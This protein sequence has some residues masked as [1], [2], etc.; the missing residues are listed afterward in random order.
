MQSGISYF[1]SSIKQPYEAVTGDT[2][3]SEEGV[4]GGGAG[5]TG[6]HVTCA[7]RYT[8]LPCPALF[9]YPRRLRKSH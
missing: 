9:N 6:V 3:V 2:E 5:H 7:V 1:F 8:G 4:V